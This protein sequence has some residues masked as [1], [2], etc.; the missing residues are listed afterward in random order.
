MPFVKHNL[1][2][3]LKY[4]RGWEERRE[5]YWGLKTA[6]AQRVRVLKVLAGDT[7]HFSLYALEVAG[8]SRH[9]PTNSDE[10]G[11]KSING[12]SPDFGMMLIDPKL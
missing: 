10:R 11:G 7:T 4:N 12:K 1:P 6:G 3:D 8:V 9:E 2:Q 5:T